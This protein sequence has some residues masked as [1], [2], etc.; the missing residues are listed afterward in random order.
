VDL[1]HGALPDMTASALRRLAGRIERLE[2]QLGVPSEPQ[3][4]SNED[5]WFYQI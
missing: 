2:K 1:E 4:K 5:A 3:V